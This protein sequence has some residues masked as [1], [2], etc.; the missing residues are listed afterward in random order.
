MAAYQPLNDVHDDTTNALIAHEAESSMGNRC[1]GAMAGM[2]A[3]FGSGFIVAGIMLPIQTFVVDLGSIASTVLTRVEI[4]FS[5]RGVELIVESSDTISEAV[6]ARAFRVDAALPEEYAGVYM[7]SLAVAIIA[8]VFAACI[9]VP[10][11]FLVRSTSG[12]CRYAY[13]IVLLL[14]SMQIGLATVL[15]FTKGNPAK[16]DIPAE[17]LTVLTALLATIGGDLK[18]SPGAGLYLFGAATASLLGGSVFAGA[19]L[20]RRGR[21]RANVLRPVYVEGANPAQYEYRQSSMSP[22][23]AQASPDY[24][25]PQQYQNPQPQQYQNPEVQQYQPHQESN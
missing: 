15:L 24:Q 14:A 20:S 13:P 9:G 10:L 17:L 4:T 7:F 16:E 11:S 18:T 22:I 1:L 5:L 8:I 21:S 25:Q 23:N 2:G 6:G 19:Y 3:I 12:C